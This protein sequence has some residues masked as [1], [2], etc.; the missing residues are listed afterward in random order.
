[1]TGQRKLVPFPRAECRS[2][3]TWSV[4]LMG[5]C[6][7]F[8][9]AAR[10]E[11][12]PITWQWAAPV[13]G[14]GCPSGPCEIAAVVPLGTAI[15]VSLTLDPVAPTYPNP[16]APCYWGDASASL[17]VMGLTY[18]SQ[19]FIF[20]D[21]Y[22]FAGN[23]AP[24]GTFDWVEVVVPSWGTSPAG[25]A[26]PGGWFPAS[27]GYYPGLWWLG[28]LTSIQPTTVFSQFPSFRTGTS[29]PPETFMAN[30][31]PVPEP[32]TWLLLSTVLSAAGAK[33]R[34]KRG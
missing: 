14:Y 20:I 2:R 12:A 34:F 17:N 5:V 31:Q 25:Q 6:L 24:P 28:D 16:L 7:L 9:G 32:S 21:A 8:F 30:L 19:A 1:M 27:A 3:S 4:G 18:T 29:V 11:A 10:A 22:G 26:L 15:T 33:R 23:C 13:T